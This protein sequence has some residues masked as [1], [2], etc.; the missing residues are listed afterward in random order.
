MELPTSH[1]GETSASAHHARR[2]SKLVFLAL[3]ILA[4]N[5]KLLHHLLHILKLLEQ[6]VYISNS[7][8]ASCGNTALSEGFT[9]EA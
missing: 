1:T 8:S 6:P 2:K 3:C 9:I 4:H 5:S 7:I